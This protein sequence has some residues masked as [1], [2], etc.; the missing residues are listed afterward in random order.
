M[1][2]NT[3]SEQTSCESGRAEE[4]GFILV[5]VIVLLAILTI[6]GT[7][8][9][10]KSTVEVRVSAGSVQ[11]EQAL[12]AASWKRVT[13]DPVLQAAAEENVPAGGL[14]GFAVM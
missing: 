12:A 6:I 4:R 5:S 3:H 13:V 7:V 9:T 1:K 2:K 14:P 10:M 8:A 11:S